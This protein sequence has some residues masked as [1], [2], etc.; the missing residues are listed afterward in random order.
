M[1]KTKFRNLAK[2]SLVYNQSTEASAQP[3]VSLG[4]GTAILAP[5]KACESCWP[6]AYHFV[7]MA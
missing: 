6:N 1:L 5:I 3:A 4:D 2:I 7:L